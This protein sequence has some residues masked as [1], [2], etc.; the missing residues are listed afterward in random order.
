MTHRY[1]QIEKEITPEEKVFTKW[2]KAATTRWGAYISDI[3][4]RAILKAHNLS[5]KP[6]IGLEIGCEG[7]RWSKMLIDLQWTM[8][9]T[10]VNE[11]VLTLCK[12]RIPTA[13][14]VLVSPNDHGVSCASES[15]DLLLC[16]EVPPVIQAD[17]FINEAFRVLQKDGLIVGVFW[18]LFSFRGFLA[19]TRASL[20]GRVDYYKI[21]YP[22]WKKRLARRGFDVLWEEG[23]CWFPFNRFS[24]SAFVL[25]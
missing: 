10:D 13:D 17:W 15:V 1:T 19:H 14:C 20:K 8:I 3:E 9:C 23:Y 12:N 16:V 4:K 25:V 11:K 24:D 6:K 2:E 22:F 7:G 21:A 5:N 18:N